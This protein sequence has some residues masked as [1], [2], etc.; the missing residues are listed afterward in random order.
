MPNTNVYHDQSSTINNK[1]PTTKDLKQNQ[2]FQ[3]IIIWVCYISATPSIKISFTR[4]QLQ[5]NT[6]DK[7]I[8]SSKSNINNIKVNSRCVAF[9]FQ[10][11]KFEESFVKQIRTISQSN[12]KFADKASMNISPANISNSRY[13][14]DPTCYLQTKSK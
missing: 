9:Q 13:M 11:Q 4:Y 10:Y 12:Y 1:N 6:L 5:Y 3:Q 14:L 2:Y 8:M 7:N